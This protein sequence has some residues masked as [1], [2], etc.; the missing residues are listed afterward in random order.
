MN[1]R[2]F[3]VIGTVL[4]VVLLVVLL[5]IKPGDIPP[6]IQDST[7]IKDKASIEVGQKT[8]DDNIVKDSE[9]VENNMNSE[10]YFDENGTK[11]FIIKA[12]DMPI[13]G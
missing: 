13:L 11:H 6:S 1:I 3:L 5:P 10:F 8:T 7:E 4:S 9:I 2:T 12:M